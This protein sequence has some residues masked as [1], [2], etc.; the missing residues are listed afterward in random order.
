VA[1]NGLIA[2]AEVDHTAL[3]AGLVTRPL[4]LETAFQAAGL[5]CMAVEAKMALPERVDSIRWMGQATDGDMLGVMVQVREDGCYDIDIDGPSGA[6][7][8]VRGFRMV[9]TGPLSDPD[10]FEVPEDGW[11]VVLKGAAVTPVKSTGSEALAHPYEAMAARWGNARGERILDEE[12]VWLSA[13]GRPR[14][15]RDRLAGQTAARAAVRALTQWDADDFSV[16]RD[17]DGAPE[18]VSC[19]SLP[20]A[21]SLTHSDGGALAVAGVG[22]GRLGI[23]A[24]PIVLRSPA[25]TRAW[26]TPSEQRRDAAS[27]LAVTRAWCAKEAVLKALGT[28][29]RLHPRSVEVREVVGRRLHISLTG[30]AAERFAELGGC[31][32]VCTW[33]VVERVVVVVASLH[34]KNSDSHAVHFLQTQRHAG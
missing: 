27:A 12:R 22:S 16:E 2:D 26:L 18:V 13:R 24:E 9:V 11:P 7:L 30:D 25:F 1:A 32:I 4:I 14:R 33:A 6:V 31:A 28:G 10:R 20:V 29:L 17:S 34:S 5:H 3:G 19:H 15:I 21:V 8:R 23:D